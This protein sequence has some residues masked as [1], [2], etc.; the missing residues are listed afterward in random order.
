MVVTP[1]N[2]RPVGEVAV[3]HAPPIMPFPIIP[4]VVGGPGVFVGVGAAAFLLCV[5]L[6]V[7]LRSVV[8]PVWQR[9]V[10]DLAWVGLLVMALWPSP[11]L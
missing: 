1:V 5:G 8:P 11:V 4:R 6:G 9:L 2:V 3:H 10:P 7:G